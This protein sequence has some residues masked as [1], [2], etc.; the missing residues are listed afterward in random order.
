[1]SDHDHADCDCDDCRRERGALVS[2]L[3]PPQKR[4]PVIP[5]LDS[6]FP[7]VGGVSCIDEG[8]KIRLT[9][10]VNLSTSELSELVDMVGTVSPMTTC[11]S[12]TEQPSWLVGYGLLESVQDTRLRGFKEGLMVRMD[13]VSTGPMYVYS[14]QE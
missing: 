6:I 10:L 7:E 14:R 3:R 11:A 2:R 9:A 4:L 12:R 13:I 1:M 5:S 8:D